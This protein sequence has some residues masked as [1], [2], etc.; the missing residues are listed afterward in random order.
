MIREQDLFQVGRMGAPHSLKG[1]IDCRYSDDVFMQD[2]NTW[3]FCRIDGL[4]VPFLLEDWRQTGSGTAILKFRD[5]DTADSVRMLTDCAL[6]F[7][8]DSVPDMDGR[9]SSW[10]MLTGFSVSDQ[11]AGEIG[12]VET[13]D[14]SSEN[15]LLYVLTKGGKEVV[16]P[17]HPDLVSS[18]DTK[19]RRLCLR[20]PEGLL[21]LNNTTD[22][23]E[24]I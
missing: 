3:V 24:T 23:T 16:L 7:P 19:K 2:T 17:V 12:E 15:V 18:I 4:P 10:Q 22:D 9:L 11:A 21:T 6:L 13:V 8:K 5:Y 20:L 14:D 1:E